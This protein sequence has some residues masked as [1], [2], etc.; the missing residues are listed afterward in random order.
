VE[1]LCDVG[2]IGHIAILIRND[3]FK[4]LIP[5]VYGQA[6]LT[7]DAVSTEIHDTVSREPVKI[8]V[9]DCVVDFTRDYAQELTSVEK[10]ELLL[11]LKWG[12]ESFQL[13]HQIKGM[14]F[15]SEALGDMGSSVDHLFTHPIQCGLSKWESLQAAE[16][17]VK[18]FIH[19]KG[20]TIE[21]HHIL[22]KHLKIAYH[23]GLSRLNQDN[24]DIVQCDAGVRYGEKTIGV[25][26]AVEAHQ[27]SLEICARIAEGVR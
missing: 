3:P 22:K 17:L 8:N 9:F 15:V 1:S 21:R 19:K 5:L 16:K 20:G 23:L 27:A 6:T 24:V 7:A 26:E 11:Y 14:T 25:Q 18:T 10:K 13:I 12:L 2:P 4:M